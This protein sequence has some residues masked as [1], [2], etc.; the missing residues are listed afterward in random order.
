MKALAA[1]A[2]VA[3]AAAVLVGAIALSDTGSGGSPSTSTT[4]TPGCAG[5]L[6][7]GTGQAPSWASIPGA[8]T[9]PPALQLGLRQPISA[10]ASPPQAPSAPQQ[11]P[12]APGSSQVGASLCAPGYGGAA[13]G[14]RPGGATATFDPGN[15]I[16][17]QVFY[18]TASMT[19]EQIAQFIAAKNSGCLADN[20]WCA[21]NLRVSWPAIPADGDCQQ[22]PAGQNADAATAIAAFSTACGINPQVMLVTWQKESQGLERTSPSAASYNAAWGWNCPDTGP[23]G[24]ANC[25]PSAAGFINQLHGM[26]AQWA[27]Y[28][29]RIPAGYYPYQVGKTVTILWNV[30]ESGCG[31]GPVTIQNVATASLYVYT[32]YQPNAAAIATGS[33]AGDSCSAY[34]NRNFFLLFHKYFGDTGGGLAT[35]DETNAGTGTPAT[36]GV[37][38]VPVNYSGTTVTIPS[39][40]AVP[41]NMRGQV[42]TAPTPKVA[43]AIA[44]GLTWLGTPYS[45]GG[46]GSGGPSTG[47]CDSTS[48]SGCSTVGFDCSGLTQYVAARWGAS[49]PRASTDQRNPSAG[50]PWSAAQPG[51]LQ[52]H[53]GHITIYIGTFSGVRMRLEAP[54]T[55]STVRISPVDAGTDDMVYRYWT[56]TT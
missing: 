51:D 38:S 12:T 15:I 32:P 48:S 22:I 21:R 4:S 55:G 10:A 1:I 13:A 42:I 30:E 19:A 8:P 41:E 36:G 26:A 18:D 35:G 37:G 24:S 39:V 2:G 27:R 49:I 56:A 23:G 53:P 54:Y 50:V 11:Q 45:W 20:H 25:D 14:A 52:G 7:G 16:S 17:D 34:G 6:L 33:G 40:A 5:Q 31:G 47:I 9:S 43:A 28:R 46:G 44:A 29:K 3:T